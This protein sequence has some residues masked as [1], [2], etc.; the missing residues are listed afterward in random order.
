MESAERG[1]VVH[2]KA[3]LRRRLIAARR[4]RP[5]ELLRRDSARLADVALRGF[6][7]S[8]RTIAAYAAFGTEPDTRPLIDMLRQ[9]GV[10]VL[11]PVLLPDGDLDWAIYEGW[12]A[13]VPGLRGLREPTGPKL[14]VDAVAEADAVLVPALAVDR[15]GRRLGRGGGS[16]DRALCRVDRSRTLALVHDDE[17]LAEVPAEAHDRRVG[18]ALTPSGLLIFRD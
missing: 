6:P 14:G 4:A 7:A 13:L 9:R 5:V 1:D 2:A 17:V 18:G 11:L 8:I 12:D 16:F 3:V 15:T 10:R